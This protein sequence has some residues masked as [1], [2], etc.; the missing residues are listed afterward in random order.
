MWNTLFAI[1]I[2]ASVSFSAASL[3]IELDK[4]RATFLATIDKPPS[5]PTYRRTTSAD[6]GNSQYSASRLD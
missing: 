3:A 4:Q 6:N 2:A 5:E 1:G